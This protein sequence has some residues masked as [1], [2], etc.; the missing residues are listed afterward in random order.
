M[1]NALLLVLF[2]LN[3]S[4]SFSQRFDRIDS[5]PV[6]ENGN[7][8]RNPWAGGINFPAINSVDVNGDGKKDLFLFDKHNNRITVFVNNGSANYHDAWD[9][10][11]E[12][13]DKFPVIR[14]WVLMYDYNNDG[15]EDLFTLSP[16]S[17]SAMAVYRNDYT[18]ATG[19]QWTL[20]DDYLDEAFDVIRQNIFVN[21]VSLPA[22]SDID[23]DGDMDILGYNSL[24]DGRIAFHKNYSMENY[25]VAD[26]LDFKY[27]TGCW[28]NFSLLIGGANQVGCF[29]CPCRERRPGTDSVFEEPSS[30]QSEAAPLDDTIS[31]IY[32]IDIDGDG[33]KDLLVGDVASFNTLLIVNDGTNVAADMGS[34]DINFPSYDVAADFDGFHYHNYID[35]DN[36][37]IK[38]LLVNPNFNENIHG[39]WFYKNNGTN[40]APIFENIE[41]SFLQ[42]EMID[43]GENATPVLVD[44]DNDG[45]LDLVVGY[46]EFQNGP[47]THKIGLRYYKNVGT[48][49]NPAFDLIDKDMATI[50]QYNFASPIVPTFGD[51]DGDGD[52]DLI[53][54]IGDGRLAYFVNTGGAGNPSNF[55]Y[56]SYYYSR[57]DIGKMA[58]PQIYD[59]DNDGK[60][61]LLI[62]EQ[63]G[64][65]NFFKNIGSVSV[66]TFDSI[67]MNDTL[68]CINLQAIGTPDG[69]TC[70]FFYDSLGSKRLLVAEET[71]F[72]HKYDSISGNLN[73]CFRQY[74]LVNDTSESSRIKFNITV[75]GGDLN[76][77]GLI[78]L[79]IGQSTGGV[80]VRYQHNGTISVPEIS[81]IKPSLEIFPSPVNTLLHLKF[82][83]LNSNS[84]SII[85]LINCNGDV[86]AEKIINEIETEIETTTFA[87]GIYCIQLISGGNSVSR[88]VIVSH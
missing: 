75:S 85:R 10:A 41:N 44:Y 1:K 83:N 78:D 86:V 81:Q 56:V 35:I 25:G 39:L 31:G 47:N 40:A 46:D 63:N 37:G 2:L 15:K 7:A 33:D 61:D 82:Y 4:L 68:G 87:Q 84:K 27:E 6:T 55:V 20:V 18:P 50:S 62:G 79:V 32:I 88:K 21:G 12:Y 69:F 74:G 51:M 57:I 48:S 59:L 73:G 14:Q 13:R 45:L 5:I 49:F 67:P 28:G 72:I 64:F 26:S 66:A 58:T 9:Y 23:G 53:V 76:G 65:V 30:N 17:G 71:G 36:D 80:E 16:I 42:N 29:H 34:Q 38:D 52:K 24:P 54:G 3:Y 11:P 70:P 43:V 77:D 8:L 19:L 22:L 60:N